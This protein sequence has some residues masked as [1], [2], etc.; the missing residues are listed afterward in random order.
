LKLLKLLSRRIAE[1]GEMKRGVASFK[2]H[3]TLGITLQRCNAA[4]IL[5]SKPQITVFHSKFVRYPKHHRWANDDDDSAPEI[6]D[7]Y[8]GI[9]APHDIPE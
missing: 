1:R 7:D 5:Q 3:Q 8:E 4:Q 2:L 9:T 6:D